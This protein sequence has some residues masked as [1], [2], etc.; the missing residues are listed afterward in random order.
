MLF[1]IIIKIF[2]ARIID[3]SLGTFR[4]I[5]TV[6]GK[7]YYPSIIAFFEVIVWFYVAKEA[8][9]VKTNNILVP[10]SYALGYATGT[11]IGSLISKYLINSYYEI[12][13]YNFND[14]VIKYLK[15]QNVKYYII[16]NNSDNKF[17]I[18]YFLK[19]GLT[20][21]LIVLHKLSKDCIIYTSEI[22]KNNQL[23]KCNNLLQT[24]NNM[25]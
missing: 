1:L 12:K 19:R 3:V 6:K 4:T 25:L 9:L 16:K 20:Q 18:T 21:R 15:R 2:F 11:L 8:L 24:E 22:T 17:L 7:I 5:L 10:V 13:I 14:K 23:F